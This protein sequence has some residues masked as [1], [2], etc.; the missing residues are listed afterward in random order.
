MRPM[1][2]AILVAAASPQAPVQNA[3]SE[4]LLPP[5]EAPLTV[6]E[7][8][9][10]KRSSRYD[11]V[12]AF[13]GGLEALPHGDRITT[14][15]IGRTTEGRELVAVTASLAD[16]AADRANVVVNAN[17]HSG[18]IEGK[19]ACQLLLRDIALGGHTDVLEE[20][21]VT[22]IPVY[23]ADS[24]DKISRRERVTQNGPDGG[25]GRRP[26]AMGLDL[27]RDFVKCE[28]PETRALLG[29]INELEPIAFMDLH[30]TNGS[31]HGYDL[32]YAPSLSVNAEPGVLNATNVLLFGIRARLESRDGVYT[33]DYGNFRYPPRERGSRGQRPDPIGWDTYDPRPRFG[34]N[35]M[36]VRGIV[37]ILSEAYSY[38]PYERR[39][40]VTY[41]F[42]LECLREIGRQRAAIEGLLA[43]P[44]L[45]DTFRIE[46]A[47]REPERMEVRVGVIDSRIIDVDPDEE[48]VQEGR[49]R[50]ASPRE[51]AR[52][53]EMDVRR[54]FS[55]AR[56][57]PLGEAWAIAEPSGRVLELL[58]LHLGAPPLRL[59][60]PLD[61]TAQV[62]VAEDLQRAERLFQGHHEVTLKGEFMGGGQTLLPAGT[63]LVPSTR[64]TAQLLHPL[65]D[66]SFTTWN[67]F[68]DAMEH[69]GDPD[70]PSTVWIHPCLRLD[71]L[72][73]GIRFH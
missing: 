60:E 65:S 4:S 73:E 29:L 28:A 59:E 19:V 18:E 35:M 67:L 68:D 69:P 7:R 71:E 39:V 24:N 50:I 58:E 56:E 6:A 8:S 51:D 53:V 61:V 1:F 72:P 36:G 10:F 41:V 33:F 32:T 3:P 54:G 31:A 47:L 62:F 26:N 64:L 45:A 66:D 20:L 30:T 42:T 27:N 12:L 52:L 57:V 23:N 25:V 34:T 70:D 38:L 17:I 15:V 5:R 14:R 46:P 2:L 48:G 16:G 11:E 44:D 22:F 40:E 21:N 55:A 37:S 13:L 9:G 63:V 43:A 49:R